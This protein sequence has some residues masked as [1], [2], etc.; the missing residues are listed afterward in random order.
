MAKERA[1]LWR[2]SKSV[3]AT[4]PYPTVGLRSGRKS[5]GKPVVVRRRCDGR[6]QTVRRKNKGGR[7]PRVGQAIWQIDVETKGGR[8]GEKPVCT[9]GSAESR[10][11]VG[12][13]GSQQKRA[14]TEKAIQ[15]AESSS[16]MSDDVIRMARVCMTQMKQRMCD[17]M[18]G[19]I[20]GPRGRSQMAHGSNCK[21]AS[22]RIAP[23]SDRLTS[24]LPRQ[25]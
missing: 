23:V 24:W 2:R 11:W 25:E 4:D 14:A 10:R 3:T 15:H 18:S 22:E 17:W 7:K 5:P 19:C 8:T 6:R 1:E 20:A 12:I 9:L 13:C 16:G 21:S